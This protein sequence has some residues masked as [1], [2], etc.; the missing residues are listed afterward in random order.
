MALVRFTSTLFFIVRVYVPFGSDVVIP[1]MVFGML[2]GRASPIG[3][4]AFPLAITLPGTSLGTTTRP[5]SATPPLARRDDPAVG[6]VRPVGPLFLFVL[7]SLCF[8]FQRTEGIISGFVLKE[9]RMRAPFVL[10]FPERS[11]Q[12]QY[13]LLLPRQVITEGAI[14]KDGRR[15]RILRAPF[16]E[17]PR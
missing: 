16:P 6:A 3:V 15:Y 13:F 12:G 4:A 8:L 14:S 17:T 2:L 10:Y 7:L 11:S 9:G 5:A 1:P